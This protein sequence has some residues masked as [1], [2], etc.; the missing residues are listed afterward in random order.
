MALDLKYVAAGTEEIKSYVGWDGMTLGEFVDEYLKI[1]MSDSV[2]TV[3]NRPVS[4]SNFE[5]RDGDKI[6]VT[7]KTH[8]SGVLA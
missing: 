1:N 4:D 8:K 5:L 7:P 6:Q 2:V 3:N